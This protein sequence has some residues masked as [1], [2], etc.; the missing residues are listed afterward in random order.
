MAIMGNFQN[1][2]SILSGLA[3]GSINLGVVKYTAEYSKETKKL[4][5][6]FSTSLRIIILCSALVSIICIAFSTFFSKR[7]L[8][9]GNY[10]N[11][12]I[13]FGVGVFLFSLNTII[14]S[15]LNG[16]KEIR[17][18]TITNIV[19]SFV[20]FLLTGVLIYFQRINGALLSLVLS[21]ACIFFVALYFLYQCEWF[22]TSMLLGG[23]DKAVAKRL[24]R[25][26]LMG[27]TST[28]VIP[29]SLLL[30]RNYISKQVSTGD[31]G[32]W[33]A[34]NRISSIYLMLITTSLS[35]YY[36]PKL[37]ETHDTIEIRKE[38][39][40]AF[41][42]VMPIVLFMSACIFFL[43][44]FIIRVVFSH[45]FG[46]MEPLFL[47]QLIGDNIKIASWLI[48]F[49]MLAK[50]MTK[51]Y[52]ITEVIFSAT[53]FLLSILFI[54]KYGTVG[55]TYAY[56]INYTGYLITCYLVLRKRIGW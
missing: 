6:L 36:L 34:I 8:H 19:S 1:F 4:G 43:R 13:L 46:P 25:F 11:L 22:S 32:Y 24:F 33:E 5:S 49:L 52:I 12:F 44:F 54:N 15:I 40:T 21:Q 51:L 31:A 29:M 35:I 39:G 53:Y 50:A 14:L 17:K 27:I 10:S 41:K 23:L 18:F 38:I 48:A 9:S 3:T 30:I 16:K 56:A 20:S 26:S 2:I 7:I 55:A 28:I 45:Q 42:I 37:S 47:F